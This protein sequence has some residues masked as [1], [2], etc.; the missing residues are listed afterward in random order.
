M[1]ESTALDQNGQC[2]SL[3]LVAGPKHG[4]HAASL[5]DGSNRELNNA[6]FLVDATGLSAH[7]LVDEL[8]EG[9]IETGEVGLQLFDL[10]AAE[11]AASGDS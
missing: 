1:G 3:S 9:V 5:G 10:S 4:S 6:L 2:G 8:Q 11:R 7:S